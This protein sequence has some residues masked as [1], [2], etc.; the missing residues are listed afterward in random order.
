MKFIAIQKKKGIPENHDCFYD[1][2]VSFPI[3]ISNK[4]HEYDV[5]TRRE[6]LCSDR[7]LT[8]KPVFWAAMLLVLHYDITSELQP[9]VLRKLSEIISVHKHKNVK[10]RRHDKQVR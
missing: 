3:H 1:D 9:A 10:V 6:W 4:R 7:K 2:E 8:M 5:E